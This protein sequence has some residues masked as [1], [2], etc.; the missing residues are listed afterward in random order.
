MDGTLYMIF[1][2]LIG[3]HGKLVSAEE[4]QAAVEEFLAY[5]EKLNE[6]DIAKTGAHAFYAN[7]WSKG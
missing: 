2:Q 3:L 4:R 7:R 5:L 1:A 6:A